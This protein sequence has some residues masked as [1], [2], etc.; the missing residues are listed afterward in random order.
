MYSCTKGKDG[1]IY[2]FKLNE[3]NKKIRTKNENVIHCDINI[4]ECKTLCRQSLPAKNIKTPCKKK[5]GLFVDQKEVKDYC[6]SK[7]PG[8]YKRGDRQKIADIM[9]QVLRGEISEEKGDQLINKIKK[10]K[11]PQIILSVNKKKSPKTVTF[12]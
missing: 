3:N 11:S 9:N 5:K 12:K 10:I 6:R 1:R 7:K 2:V 4:P 8:D